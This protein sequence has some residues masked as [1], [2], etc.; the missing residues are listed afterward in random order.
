MKMNIAILEIKEFLNQSEEG[1][2][3]M[4]QDLDD[5]EF[6]QRLAEFGEDFVID[7]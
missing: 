5:Y 7:D 6:Q 3:P 4:D 2:T 1:Q